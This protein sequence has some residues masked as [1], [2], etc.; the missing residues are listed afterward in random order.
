MKIALFT[1]GIYPYVIGGMQKHSFCLAKYLAQKKIHVDVYHYNQSKY[2]PSALEF[3]SEEEKLFIHPVLLNF[4]TLAPFP[5]HYIVESYLYSLRIYKEFLKRSE[6]DFIYAKGFTAWKLLLEKKKG[7]TGPPVGINFHGYEMF[8]HAANLKSWLEQILLLRKPVRKNV[9]RADYLFSYGKGITSILCQHLNVKKVKIIEIPAGIEKEWLVEKAGAV[10]RKRKFIFVGRFERRKGIM[11]LSQAIEQLRSDQYT[12]DFIGDIPRSYHL[13][14]PNVVY[15]GKIQDPR[16]IRE[17]YQ[18]MDILVCPSYSEGMPNVILEGM[19]NG[20]AV[21][22]S[23]TGATGTMVS[24]SVG[25]LIKNNKPGTI[26]KALS[27]AINVSD[28]E[29]LDKKKA[30]LKMIKENFLWEEIIDHLVKELSRI[31]K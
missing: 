24:D 11:E 13:D 31:K 26:V 27:E 8:Q 12:F 4:P 7:K 25:W 2:D 10:E 3:F 19:A 28:K 29:L 30:S 6:V 5:G 15:H 17:I 23:D 22:A 9:Y 16:K 1:D 18:G 20:L 21:I 14:K